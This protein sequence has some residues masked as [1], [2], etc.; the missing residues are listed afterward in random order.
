MLTVISF[1]SLA[2]EHR[3]VNSDIAYVNS[4]LIRVC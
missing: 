2:I 3:F 1:T 4:D